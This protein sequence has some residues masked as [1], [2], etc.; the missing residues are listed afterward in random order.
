[1]MINDDID[2]PVATYL[3]PGGEHAELISQFSE[4]VKGLRGAAALRG[5]D[6]SEVPIPA[7]LFEIL[8]KSAAELQRGRSVSIIPNERM[9]TT[10][11]A[12]Q[13]LGISRPTLVK[14][15]ERGEV[16]FSKV[17]RHRRVQL[18]DL[19]KYKKRQATERRTTL[20]KVA[21]GTPGDETFYDP[22][23]PLRSEG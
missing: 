20:Q 5:P 9:M 8:V 16:P 19:L 3:A 18:S 1:M 12:A 6:G 7:E 10:Q 13:L 4:I 23:K 15:L 11:E 22:R 17:G 21:A 14:M 2:T